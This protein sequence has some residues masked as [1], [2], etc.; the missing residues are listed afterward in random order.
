MGNLMLKLARLFGGDIVK[1]I[2]KQI[3]KAASGD[4]SKRAVQGFFYELG[5]QVSREA[6][7]KTNK[8]LWELT[9]STLQELSKTAVDQF[10]RGLD[11]DD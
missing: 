3:H 1:L 7:G 6:G 5:K 4:V 9:E 11:A 2:A 8:A 10:H